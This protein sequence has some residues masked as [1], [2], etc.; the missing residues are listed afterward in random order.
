MTP[1]LRIGAI[2]CG[3]LSSSCHLPAI[4][5]LPELDLVALCDLDRGRLAAAAQQFNVRETFTDFEHMLDTLALDGVSVIGPPDLHVAAAKSLLRRQVPFLTEKPLATKVAD[6]LELATLAAAHGD[7]GMVAYTSR[8]APAQRLAW[9]ISRAP[10]FGTLSFVSTAHRTQ[11]AMYTYWDLED[12][13]EAFIHLHGVHAIDLWRFFGG[14]PEEVS[15]SIA[16]WRVE[17]QDPLHARGSIVAF[18][19]SA[20]GPH[21][22][23]QMKAGNAYNGAID[24]DVMGEL[25]RV[26]VES[27]MTLRYDGPRAWMAD[28]MAGDVLADKI[29]AEQPAGC[30]VG[31]GLVHPA[32][33]PDFFR[34]EWLAF[35]RNVIAGTPLSPSIADGCRTVLL[36]DAIC[37]SLRQGGPFVKVDG[38]EHPADD[39]RRRRE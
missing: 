10:E 24:S 1:P 27:D 16:G 4:R 17:K 25:G 7:C 18:V 34:L 21:G 3:G 22:I 15:A 9:R 39:G 35:A 36:A 23:V 13:Q 2:G 26:R 12:P 29:T 32:Y 11:A 30:F 31:T 8:A 38:C 28:L 6:A 5:A 33:Y 37:R 20:K 14:D 19:R